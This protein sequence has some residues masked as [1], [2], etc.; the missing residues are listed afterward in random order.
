MLPIKYCTRLA[1]GLITIL[2]LGLL[3]GCDDKDD[4]NAIFSNKKWVA[5]YTATTTDWNDDNKYEITKDFDTAT[6]NTTSY[7]V[8]TGTNTIQI[9]G[10]STTWTGKW[11][12]N[13]SDRTFKITNLTKTGGNGASELEIR[14]LNYV[15]TATYYRGDENLVKLF[16]SDKKN[17]ILLRAE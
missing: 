10:V 3:S 8:T 7:R 15:A 5:V 1:F 11:T 16:Q 6:E 2:A 12:A 14:F 4:I 13:G 9:K 17:Y